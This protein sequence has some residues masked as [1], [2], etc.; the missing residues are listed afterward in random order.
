[1]RSVSGIISA[2]LLATIMKYVLQYFVSFIHNAALLAFFMA[3]CL[4]H[5]VP[6]GV[7]L[8]PIYGL[9]TRHP[10]PHHPILYKY[11]E[12]PDCEAMPPKKIV[13]TSGFCPYLSLFLIRIPSHFP[14]TFFCSYHLLPFAPHST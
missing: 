6:K 12:Q 9:P 13:K 1:M 11:I 8:N 7:L 10:R 4:A 3:H 5:R 2:I 14:I